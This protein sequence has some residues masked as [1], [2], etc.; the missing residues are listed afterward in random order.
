LSGGVKQGRGG[1]NKAFKL[2]LNVNV[3]KT[4]KDTSKVTI[5]GSHMLFRLTPRSMT[6]DDLDLL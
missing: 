2:H 3:S 1:D 4:V 5:N 6:L